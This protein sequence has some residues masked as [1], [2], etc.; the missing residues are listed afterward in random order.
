M[1]NYNTPMMITY[2]NTSLQYIIAR[3]TTQLNTR[4]VEQMHHRNIIYRIISQYVMIIYHH[5][6]QLA[7]FTYRLSK[8][9][10]DLRH[11]GNI[12]I[13]NQNTPPYQ[14]NNDQYNIITQTNAST[15]HNN[16]G[17]QHTSIHHHITHQ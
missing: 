11:H 13:L 12:Q 9:S 4:Q 5:K 10:S 16:T 14:K 7:H 2:T 1:H 17:P 6:L 8:L 15:Q 3:F